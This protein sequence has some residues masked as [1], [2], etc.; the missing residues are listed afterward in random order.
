M[1]CFC[2]FIIFEHVDFHLILFP[3]LGGISL[4]ADELSWILSFPSSE[5]VF[6][7]ALFLKIISL[8]IEVFPILFVQH[9]E[10]A[11]LLSFDP[12]GFLSRTFLIC[13]V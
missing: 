8:Y 1:C 2:S 10:Y 13:D 7:S 4:G 6:I 9:F 12:H 3:F 5:N 11:F